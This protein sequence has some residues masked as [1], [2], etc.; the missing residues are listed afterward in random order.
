MLRPSSSLKRNRGYWKLNASLLRSELFCMEIR[1]IIANVSDDASLSSY[2]SK[3]E[4]L[5]YKI[6]NFSISFSKQLKFSA[7]LEENELIREI[8]Q[9][10]NKSTISDS[11]RR[12]LLTL[13]TK[14]DDIYTKK[15]KGAILDLRPSGLRKGRKT[16]PIL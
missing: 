1:N 6:R 4:F 2:I 7:Q 11:D 14:L 15:A 3:W 10:C 8:Y 16:L 13:Q 5:K 9:C 12:N